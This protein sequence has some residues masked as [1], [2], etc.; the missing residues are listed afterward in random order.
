MPPFCLIK[1]SGWLAIIIKVIPFLKKNKTQQRTL[2][3][4]PNHNVSQAGKKNH[5]IKAALVE[6]AKKERKIRSPSPSKDHRAGKVNR[7]KAPLLIPLK[8]D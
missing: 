5:P 7:G 3:T 4:V 6:P 8:S 1:L 2:K